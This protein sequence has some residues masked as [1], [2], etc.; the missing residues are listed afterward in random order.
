MLVI[1]NDTICEE[2][3][4]IQT[5]AGADVEVVD[6]IAEAKQ[7]LS[8]GDYDKVI[9]S[10]S[11]L[12]DSP[13]QKPEDELNKLTRTLKAHSNSSHAMMRATNEA[14]YLNEVCRIVV[15]DC[16]H[17]MVWVGFA[18]DDDAKSV[19][20]AAHAGFDDG[21]LE[22][23]HL[24]WADNERGRGPTG[25]AIREGKPS[26]CRNMLTD[27]K[28]EPWRKEALKRGFASSIVLPLKDE[29]KVFGAI[30]IYSNEP[31]PFSEE[32]VKL[33]AGLADDLA[34]GIVAI[35]LR[36]AH[37]QSERSLQQSEARL[38]TL[39]GSMNEGF[40]LHEIICDDRGIPVDYRFMEVNEAFENQTGLKR[41][42][43]IGRTIN[44]ILPNND[45]YWIEIYGKVALSGEPT[46]FENYSSAIGKWYDVY[47]FCPT[48]GQFAA[49]FTDITDD[50]LQ[51][52]E[53]EITIE[54][55]HIVNKCT[56][57]IEL[58]QAVT[59]F[60]QQQSGCEA[61]GIRLRED[62]DY[63][64]FEYRG[65][66]EE[67]ILAENCL[68]SRDSNGSVIRDHF[69]NP[70]I[71]CMCGNVICGRFDPA[72]SF[73]TVNGSFW[74][75][76]T[77]ELLASTSD[78]DR[79]AR[80]RNRCNGEGYESVALIPLYTGDERLGLLQLNDRRKGI[81]STSS[82]ALWERLTASLSVALAKFKAEELLKRYQTL[83]ENSRDIIL[84]VGTD[85]RILEANDS[86]SSTYGYTH[87]ELLE[88]SIFD[89]R[90]PDSVGL[91]AAQMAEANEGGILFETVHRRKDGSTLNVEVSSCGTQIEGNRV[92][93]SII[94]DITARKQAEE[95]AAKARAEAERQAKE[96]ESFFSS[97]SD[98]VVLYDVNGNAILTNEAVKEI[99]GAE[100]PP[101]LKEQV[102]LYR[103][104]QLDGTS[105]SW[106]DMASNRALRG[107]VIRDLRY[108]IT[109]CD[110]N[111][112]VIAV[113]SSPVR[114]SNFGICGATTV[115]RDITHLVDFERRKEELYEKE[116]HIADVL[117][118][119]LI[120]DATYDIP[121]CEIAV[122]Y[123]A[124][125]KEAQVGGD[126][127]D[128]F[129][130][131]DNKIGI[132]IG[133][134][135]GKGLGAAIQVAAARHSFRSYSY[136]HSQ[137]GK[138]MTL[139]NE[140]LSRDQREGFTMITAFFAVVDLE[141]GIMTYA[142]GGHETPMHRYFDG[143]V[144][145]LEIDG[146]ALGVQSGYDYQDRSVILRPGDYVV[147]VTDGITEARPDSTDLFGIDRFKAYLSRK[148]H[149][150]ADELAEGL[151]SAA[152]GHAKG[153]LKDD[154][155]IVVFGL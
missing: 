12:D 36:E 99:F 125:L 55:L 147:M 10:P 68:C 60:F 30:T 5:E 115:Y 17:A 43:V 35:R 14:D 65:F 27:P 6:S 101:S 120:P 58:I 71:E 108:K 49:I 139:V 140:A 144:F 62:E 70:V 80:T 97:M 126:F 118:H 69:G 81:F 18:E 15:E 61:V 106:N 122:R 82:I 56:D 37:A 141:M 1:G 103:V 8:T 38:Q 16:G 135:A 98:G 67:F 63:P 148:Y 32:E 76:C 90:T 2:E 151:I 31:D 143:R 87:D 94:R 44:E 123:E 78:G 77:T 107:E 79:Q 24:T 124:A 146:R 137:P 41:D 152:K 72:K 59:T 40:A 25:T 51:Q 145:E 54:F 133:D 57:T 85:G 52:Q 104:R 134:V 66:S 142:N 50:K 149:R 21:Y 150:S 138:V 129:A 153:D 3:T 155:A 119:V 121:G 53:H 132:L 130:I 4:C 116:H 23:L 92:L 105:M 13:L 74:S 113:S 84:F 28:F 102:T 29:D 88:L 48:K 109:S 39:F 111:D 86:A 100:L 26:T 83:S 75:N 131:G 154:A 95:E 114:D 42:N 47:A 33:L 128:V 20:P 112:K 73:F 46:K 110:G 22:T 34:Y 19:R 127:Y 45:P 64:Y 7:K 96:L 89:I 11:A 93:I 117:Q 91:T 136:I 9:V